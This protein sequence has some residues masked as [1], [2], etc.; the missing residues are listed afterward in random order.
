MFLTSCV[1]LM[2]RILLENVKQ[3]YK[4][5]YY[6]DR[7]LGYGLPCFPFRGSIVVVTLMQ[8]APGWYAYLKDR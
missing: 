7:H 5:L 2:S 6:A 4:L 3:Q 8:D 1:N